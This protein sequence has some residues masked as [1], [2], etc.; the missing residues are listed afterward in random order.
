MKPQDHLF[1]AT[2]NN[3]VGEIITSARL[4]CGFTRSELSQKAQV[5]ETLLEKI[6]SGAETP[7]VHDWNQIAK[8]L[9]IS[10]DSIELG[11]LD[12][13]QEAILRSGPTENGFSIEGRFQENR[14][15]KIRELLPYFAAAID[16]E[17]WTP[18][19]NWLG[20]MNLPTA[21]IY[22]LDNQVNLRFYEQLVI[23][24]YSLGVTDLKAGIVAEYG[25]SKF[26]HGRLWGSYCRTQSPYERLR[27]YVRASPYYQCA[28]ELCCIEEHSIPDT[29]LAI[30][31]K[32]APFLFPN[33]GDYDPEAL[34][35]LDIV[36]ESTLLKVANTPLVFGDTETQHGP[37]KI[38]EI[39]SIYQG[40]NSS[41]YVMTR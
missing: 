38:E 19:R 16:S 33:L 32:P 12:E 13:I 7:A 34:S 22:N 14:C 5:S 6:E 28:F 35:Y 26:F 9:G 17:G 1:L 8:A 21:F 18:F 24:L 11:C 29:L 2:E 39:Q 25:A 20:T 3:A 41:I 27:T 15:L 23:H 40:Y 37:W 31:C 30:E 4:S 36:R 10:L